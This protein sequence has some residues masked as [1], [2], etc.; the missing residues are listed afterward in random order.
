[1]ACRF[2]GPSFSKVWSA[3]AGMPEDL[4]EPDPVGWDG[5]SEPPK[6]TSQHAYAFGGVVI[7]PTGRVLLREVARDVAE[8]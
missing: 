3:L 6:S 4:P 7:D 2:W 8:L 1:M 5:L